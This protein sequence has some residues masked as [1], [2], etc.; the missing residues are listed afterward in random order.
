MVSD[1]TI[2]LLR[3]RDSYGAFYMTNQTVSDA[4]DFYWFL[5]TDGGTTFDPADPKVSSGKVIGASW[6]SFGPFKLERSAGTDGG[7]WIYYPARYLPT[8]SK[9]SFRLP[10]TPWMAVT[11]EKDIRKI[12]AGDK[13]WT[14]RPSP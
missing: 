14:F 3:H 11:S 5:R 4:A 7:G 9:F 13:Q 10:G 6:V 8:G 12:D 1:N 2:V